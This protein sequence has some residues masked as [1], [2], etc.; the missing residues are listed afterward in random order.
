MSSKTSRGALAGLGVSIAALMAV[1]VP[2]PALAGDRT[3]H[4]APATP[5]VDAVTLPPSAPANLRAVHVDGVL[6]RIAWDR[7]VHDRMVSYVGYS[8]PVSL[9]STS[10]TSISIFELVHHWC[11]V[12]PGSTYTL[13]VEALS[14]DNHS[15]ALSAPLTITIPPASAIRR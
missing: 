3:P 1:L 12:E 11:A 2:G 6:H 14:S 13:T 9:F 8:G 5:R 7:S 15:S 10:A 4:R